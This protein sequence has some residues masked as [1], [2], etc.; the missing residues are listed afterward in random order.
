MHTPS[1]NGKTLE[2]MFKFWQDLMA[3]M[4]TGG[5]VP[6]QMPGPEAFQQGR[7]VFFD[8]LAAYCDEFMRSPQF[9]EGM[10]QTMAQSLAFRKQLNEFITSAMHAVQM[11]TAE[12]MGEVLSTLR[13][14]E[15]TLLQR[16]EEIADRLERLER[17]P[18][19]PARPAR[20]RSAPA[21]KRRR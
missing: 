16:V 9:L 2:P 15:S 13:A 20:P 19:R 11:P 1:D 10:K 4:P 21:S 5:F 17:G 7:R 12:D 3:R 18:A 8:A 6:G 14:I